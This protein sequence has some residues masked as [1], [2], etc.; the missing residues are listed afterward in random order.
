MN[1][2]IYFTTY[3]DG[4][5]HK[6]YLYVFDP[7]KKK[8]VREMEFKHN[9]LYSFWGMFVIDRKTNK[10]FSVNPGWYDQQT[11]PIVAAS[12]YSIKGGNFKLHKL[13]YDRLDHI[14]QD[15]TIVRFY[16]KSLADNAKHGL[17]FPKEGWK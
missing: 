3:G 11:V 1:N 13:V 17:L 4:I 15:T 10:I 9:Y 8:L 14:Q 6:G 12:M 16:H 7:N 5:G 2:L